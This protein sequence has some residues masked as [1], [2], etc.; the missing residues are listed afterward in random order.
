M[1]WVDRDHQF[2]VSTGHAFSTITHLKEKVARESGLKVNQFVRA[3]ILVP[4]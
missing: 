3:M 4:V 1:K 2:S